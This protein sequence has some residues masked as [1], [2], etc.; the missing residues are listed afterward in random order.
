[1]WLS[2]GSEVESPLARRFSTWLGALS[3]LCHTALHVRDVYSVTRDSDGSYSGTGADS[4]ADLACPPASTDHEPRERAV[5]LQLWVE[6]ALT[7]V[8]VSSPAANFV[9]PATRR[10]LSSRSRSSRSATN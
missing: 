1:M 3:T 8:Y 6:G 4:R 9:R 7:A 5:A 10:A 2:L